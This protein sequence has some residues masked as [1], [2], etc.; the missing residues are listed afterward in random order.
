MPG[1]GSNHD[2]NT[3]TNHNHNEH[4]R[5]ELRRQH[6]LRIE[7]S[8]RERTSSPDHPVHEESII[9]TVRE[10]DEELLD[11]DRPSNQLQQLLGGKAHSVVCWH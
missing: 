2:Q 8:G 3:T 4:A 7:S 10:E 11:V 5:K 1:T 9:T 6:R